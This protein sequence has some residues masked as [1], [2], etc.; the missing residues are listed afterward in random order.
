MR[1]LKLI[2]LSL[3]LVQGFALQH[4][5]TSDHA[6][7]DTGA[8]FERDSLAA[9]SHDADSH[10][11]ADIIETGDE[12]LGCT[13]F[14]AWKHGLSVERAQLSLGLVAHPTSSVPAPRA[15]SK[16]LATLHLAPKASPP[17]V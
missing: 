2:S 9:D 13:V 3:L 5:L 15:E 14:T 7:D 11:C 1:T 10:V 8:A 6:F 4:Q 17:A 12:S 16:P